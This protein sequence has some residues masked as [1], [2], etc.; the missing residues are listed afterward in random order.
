MRI[1]L[2]LNLQII[3]LRLKVQPSTPL[4]VREQWNHS[5]QVGLATIA[6]TIQE[7]TGFLNQSL[8]T[9]SSLHEHPMHQQIET[10]VR[11]LQQDYDNIKGT[12]QMV[13]LTQ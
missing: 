9:L 1:Q 4:E 5:I 2:E 10:E 12:T 3:E 6:R 13:T 11:E 7:F 8:A